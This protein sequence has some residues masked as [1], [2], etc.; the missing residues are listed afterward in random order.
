MINGVFFDL[1]GT[2][3]IYTDMQKAWERW[4]QALYEDFQ[5]WRLDMP[6]KAFALMCDGFLAKAEPVIK[7]HNL[8]V[9]EKRI[10]SLG[11]ELGLQLEIED[12]RKMVNNT[13]NT[14]QKFVPLDPDTIPV[15]KTLK[16]SKNLA[17]ITNF[18]HPPYIYSL[19]SDMKLINFFESII[20]SSEV[21]VKKPDPTIFSFVLKEINLKADEI[22]YVGDTR[23]DMEAAIKAGM[24]P[25]LIQRNPS[26]ENESL[27][28]YYV[29]K[30]PYLQN[31]AEIDFKS[32]KKIMSLKELI[33]LVN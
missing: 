2:L 4:L 25:I 23:E 22:C 3:L 28:D 5:E 15:L 11:L 20:I 12:I 27:D 17:L 14:W 24:Y 30:S 8:T 18:D 26:S 6:Q 7:N 29:K 9:Y 32:V 10:Y 1:F 21:G 31:G 19:L 16:K 13:I 33:N